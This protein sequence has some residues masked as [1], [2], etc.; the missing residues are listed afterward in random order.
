MKKLISS[1]L[2]VGFIS[3]GYS[4]LFTSPITDLLASSNLVVATYGIAD[5]TTKEFGG[6][7]GIGA[8]VNEFTVPTLRFDYI[9][10]G[11]WVPSANLQLQVPIN[12]AVK[13]GVPSAR[14]TPFTF[15]GIATSFNNWQNGDNGS[16]VGM[17]GIGGA[18]AFPRLNDRVGL[19]ADYERWT[20]GPFNDNQIRFGLFYKF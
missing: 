12:I 19:I 10:G 17:F 6:G 7:I 20:G 9:N 14:L 15:A 2:A 8:K 11:V 13:N 5:T 18:L 3:T 4:Q 16:P 1:L